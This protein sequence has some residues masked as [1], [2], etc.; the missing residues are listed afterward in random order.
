MTDADTVLA[1]PFCDDTSN[2]RKRTGKQDRDI[3]DPEFDWYCPSCHCGIEPVEREPSPYGGNR[4]GLA[5][6]LA[7]PNTTEFEDIE[8]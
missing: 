4:R 8:S 7:D 6:R 5:G 2:L 1:C 3:A